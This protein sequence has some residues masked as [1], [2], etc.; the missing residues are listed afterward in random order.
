MRSTAEVAPSPG[1]DAGL[2]QPQ[3]VS[4]LRDLQLAADLAGPAGA[5]VTDR[6]AQLTTFR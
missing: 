3:P 6:T 4:D 5:E 1:E 2:V